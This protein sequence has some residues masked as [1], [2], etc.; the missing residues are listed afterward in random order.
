MTPFISSKCRRKDGKR[1]TGLDSPWSEIVTEY[2]Q[3]DI[4]AGEES[5]AHNGYSWAAR[6]GTSVVLV[7]V[8]HALL[9]KNS[10][11]DCR[12]LTSAESL[13]SSSFLAARAGV[14]LPMLL[15]TRHS[16]AVSAK[17]LPVLYTQP[18]LTG[19][20]KREQYTIS[21]FRKHSWLS[22]V[23]HAYNPSIWKAETGAS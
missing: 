4:L 19:H 9:S 8:P 23:V 7:S 22:V 11:P 18:S 16:A 17:S 3:W 5:L 2:R 10:I 12:H 20:T 21:A 14:L 13:S 6:G 15:S 1:G